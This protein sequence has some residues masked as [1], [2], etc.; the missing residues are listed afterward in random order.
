MDKNE[1]ELQQ[2]LKELNNMAKLNQQMEHG[3]RRHKERAR[4]LRSKKGSMSGSK[5]KQHER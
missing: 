4:D 1:K 5:K 3:F 2:I